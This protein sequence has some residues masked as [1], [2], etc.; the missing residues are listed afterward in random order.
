MSLA[1]TPYT[2]DRN[3]PRRASFYTDDNGIEHDYEFSSSNRMTAIP[4]A[5]DAL[6]AIAIM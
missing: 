2:S 3:M 5:S 1:E 6:D 4:A